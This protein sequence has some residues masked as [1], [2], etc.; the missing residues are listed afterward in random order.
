VDMFA[1]HYCYL[2]M[3]NAALDFWRARW[4]CHKIRT[5]GNKSPAQLWNRSKSSKPKP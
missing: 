3:L 2:P 5:A 1:L 4:N